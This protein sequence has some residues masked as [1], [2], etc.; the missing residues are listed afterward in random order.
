LGSS[1]RQAGGE[2]AVLCW[3]L[4]ETSTAQ[5]D[6]KTQ[7]LALAMGLSGGRSAPL[8]RLPERML[9]WPPADGFLDLAE[10]RRFLAEFGE[11]AL[12]RE[13]QHRGLLV[14][15]GSFSAELLGWLEIGV[16]TLP[17]GDQ[18]E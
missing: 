3:W 10:R 6:R 9:D 7:V 18:A 13:L 5:G 16:E 15:G 4:F 14:A 8:E 11:P 12:Q 17:L 1:V 2:G